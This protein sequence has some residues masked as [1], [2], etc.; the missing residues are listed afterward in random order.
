MARIYFVF[1]LASGA[2]SLIYQVV[3]L[4]LAMANY[5][6]NAPVVAVVVSLFM[7]GL[8]IGSFV[9]GRVGRRLER[10][11]PSA[12]VRLYALCEFLIGLSALLVPFLLEWGREML[13]RNLSA[14]MWG[15]AGY[16][17]IVG[18]YLTVTLLPW[19]T[20][21]GATTP[22]GMTGVRLVSPP[23]SQRAFSYLYLANVLGAMIGVLVSAFVL[24]ELVG[25]TGTL[26]V[27]AALNFGIAAT[28]AVLASSWKL[29]TE[30][31]EPPP[32]S[33]APSAQVGHAT[34]WVLLATG[35]ASM[36]M[37]IVWIRVFT[38][39]LGTVVYA[40]AAVLAIYLGSTML[41]TA[42]YRALAR[43]GPIPVDLR[44]L[45]L[46]AFYSLLPILAADPRLPGDKS[47][48]WATLRVV[49]G[50]AP[51]CAALGFLTPLLV[52]RWSR[53]E[54]GR[55]G[56][57]YAVNIGGSIAGPILASFFLLPVLDERSTLVLLALPLFGA[58]VCE[59]SGRGL[60]RRVF[61]GGA[62]LASVFLVFSTRAYWDDLPSKR[63]LRDHEATVVAT[64]DGVRKQL[65]VNGNGMTVL[66]P[67]TK[68]MSH[69]PL[70]YLN[71]EPQNALVIAFG[72][73]TSFR[74]ALSWR[75]ETTAVELVPSVPKLFGYFHADADQVATAPQARVVIDDGR[76]FLRGTPER[77][78]VIVV[79]PPPP[80]SAIGSSLLYSVEFYSSVKAKLNPDGILSQWLV[81][82]APPETVSSI[83]QAVTQSF[84]QVRI[85]RSLD[86]WGY[87]VIASRAPLARRRAAAMVERMPPSAAIDMIEW[88]PYSDPALQLQAVLK[89][90]VSAQQL[91]AGA[92]ASPVMRDARPVNEYY[93]LR[94]T[95]PE[96]WRTWLAC[97]S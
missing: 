92:P 54:P 47:V 41:G 78:D 25:L 75:V 83:I 15:S 76:R 55:A 80:V 93:F 79:D 53:G 28:A 20:C 60:R 11:D 45:S 72:M 5:G 67:D 64:A 68:M 73:G 29:K 49:V 50:I 12:A 96:F 21:M 94:S 4:R 26:W 44:L 8:G 31:I 17:A 9:A 97:C 3:W 16:Y 30:V 57:A 65:L 23:H 63:V 48:G 6:V 51:F 24:I 87:H 77:Y 7:A 62:V 1:F 69:L 10:D 90:E 91:I 27:A 14:L 22:L 43:R 88:G 59:C 37:E 56:T 2:C 40:F 19:C 58:G 84:Q 42:A 13:D 95:F 46:A 86:N 74:S 34:L 89:R 35:V 71:G 70:V 81:A 82:D 61:H 66:S 18:L 38:P 33:P 36:A 52:D 32:I 85:F 39:Y